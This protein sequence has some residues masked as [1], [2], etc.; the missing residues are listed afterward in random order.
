MLGAALVSVSSIPVPSSCCVV[1]EVGDWGLEHIL[2]TLMAPSPR[3]SC[4]TGLG[5]AWRG[6]CPSPPPSLS[7]AR[8]VF[9]GLA[10]AKELIPMDFKLFSIF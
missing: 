5:W 8:G 6:P 2:R 3:V 9:K 7:P 1:W 10:K 4:G